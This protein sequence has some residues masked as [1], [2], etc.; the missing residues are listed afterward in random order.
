MSEDY[1]LSS[2]RLV[3]FIIENDIDLI[4]TL[5]QG[6]DFSFQKYSTNINFKSYQERIL[7]D[8]NPPAFLIKKEINFK[9]DVFNVRVF[10]IISV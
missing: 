7:I 6:S 3:E 4:I 10:M 8:D 1:L 9:Y 5:N 2:N